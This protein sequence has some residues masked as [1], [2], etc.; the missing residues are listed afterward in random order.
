[1]RTGFSKAA[2]KPGMHQGKAETVITFEV[3]GTDIPLSTSTFGAHPGT[4]N[5]ISL[6]CFCPVSVEE[7]LT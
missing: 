5:L 2:D 1:M 7:L 3:F 4:W 6:C